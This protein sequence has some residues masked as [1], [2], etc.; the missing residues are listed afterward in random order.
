MTSLRQLYALAGC[1]CLAWLS[2][3]FYMQAQM[4]IQNE[5]VESVV[6]TLLASS[7]VWNALLMVQN[8]ILNTSSSVF[9]S[10]YVI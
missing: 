9:C 7:T 2:V 1:Y 10:I 5:N 8:K 3:Y 6:Q 4:I